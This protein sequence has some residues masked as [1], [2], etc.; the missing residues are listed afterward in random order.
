MAGAA[1]A[2]GCPLPSGLL[3]VGGS[4]RPPVVG[5]MVGPRHLAGGWLHLWLD[6]AGVGR[7]LPFA[8]SAWSLLVLFAI[9]LRS[10]STLAGSSLRIFV[11]LSL[12]SRLF[13]CNGY[14]V[15]ACFSGGCFAVIFV[16]IL[17]E[18]LPPLLL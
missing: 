10:S 4:Y 3:A 18:A 13:I 5:P 7:R 16:V 2:P 14:F 15:A 12:L 6:V 11:V 17:V 9:G 8:S 1:V